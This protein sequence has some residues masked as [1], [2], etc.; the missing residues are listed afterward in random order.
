LLPIQVNGAEMRITRNLYMA[1]EHIRD[2][3]VDL[4]L[5]IDALC[6]N[7]SDNEEKGEQVIHMTEIYTNAEQTIVWLGPAENDSNQIIGV[8][9]G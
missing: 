1:L 8:S 4:T 7:Q 9:T 5:W 6:I 3:H 2:D